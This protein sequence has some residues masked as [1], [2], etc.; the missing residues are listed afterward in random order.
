MKNANHEPVAA[1]Q[2]GATLLTVLVA[3]ALAVCPLAAAVLAL[4][5]FHAV[6]LLALVAMA[7]GVAGVASGKIA[8]NYG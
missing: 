4:P 2:P 1:H 6:A 8:C 3:G 7:A 5:W